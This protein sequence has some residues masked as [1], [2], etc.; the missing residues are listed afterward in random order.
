MIFN[1]AVSGRKPFDIRTLC[2][3]SGSRYDPAA[4]RVLE[5]A[6]FS[7]HSKAL[8]VVHMRFLE[9]YLGCPKAITSDPKLQ[10]TLRPDTYRPFI[11]RVERYLTSTTRPAFFFVTLRTRPLTEQW[12]G[13]LKLN[14]PAILIDTEYNDPTPEIDGLLSPW[15]WLRRLFVEIGIRRIALIGETA[16][17]RDGV[18]H[19]CVHTAYLNLFPMF[20]VRVINDLTYPNANV[21]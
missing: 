14:A 8:G 7:S 11:S 3:K 9:R 6:V 10:K 5:R 16:Y 18:R 19:G 12:L 13:S 1:N 2:P 21:A 15:S 4:A 20:N 17:V